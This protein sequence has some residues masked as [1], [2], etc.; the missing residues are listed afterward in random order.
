MPKMRIIPLKK[1]D[2]YF[3]VFIIGFRKNICY[4]MI[5]YRH[6]AFDLFHF[7]TFDIFNTFPTQIYGMTRRS[8][9]S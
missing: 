2:I 6:I 1:C 8:I 3:I 9:S 4:R 7:D 5:S